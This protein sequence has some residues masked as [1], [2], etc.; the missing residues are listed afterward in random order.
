MSKYLFWGSQYVSYPSSIEPPISSPFLP[1]NDLVTS[2]Y[3]NYPNEREI[4]SGS[5][6]AG[7]NPYAPDNDNQFQLPLRIRDVAIGDKHGQFLDQSTYLNKVFEYI[8][9]GPSNGLDNTSTPVFSTALKRLLVEL[10]TLSGDLDSFI[11]FLEDSGSDE[12]DVDSIID[13]SGR[14][15]ERSTFDDSIA[16]IFGNK[17]TIGQVCSYSRALQEGIVDDIPGFCCLDAPYESNNWGETVSKISHVLTMSFLLS[18]F[19]L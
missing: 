9:V 3:S 15:Y 2:L 7:T 14:G 1:K 8:K 6:S 10:F 12:I 16:L 19:N 4:F 17:T 5:A 11:T 13:L 18:C